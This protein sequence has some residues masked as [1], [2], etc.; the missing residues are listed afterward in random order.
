MIS[1]RKLLLQAVKKCEEFDVSLDAPQL[2]LM[3]TCGLTNTELYVK[4]DEEV[5]EK[6]VRKFNSGVERLCK[7]EPLQYVL[8]YWWFCGYK[9]IV[10][11]GALIPRPETEELVGNVLADSDYYF[12]DLDKIEIADVGTGSGAIAIA[13]KKE[14]DKFNMTATDISFEALEVAKENAKINDCDIQLLQG[15]MLQPLIDKGIKL[16]ILVSNPPYIPATQQME[17]TVVDFE[18]HVALFGGDDGLF[19]YR[20]IFEKAYEVIKEHSFMAFEIGYD[21]KEAIEALVKQYFPTDR[22]EVLKDINGK[23]RM[24]FVYHNLD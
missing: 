2:L 12:K 10:N 15:D 18:P 17:K 6:Y 11:E 24:L 1:Y 21:E 4:Y 5:D 20:K 22:Y 19:F 16:D 8:G 13:L 7:G 23:N 9:M 14:E 3:E